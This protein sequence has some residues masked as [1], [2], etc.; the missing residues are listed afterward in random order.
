MDGYARSYDEV[1]LYMMLRPCDC[2]EIELDRE[3]RLSRQDGVW[4]HEYSGYCPRCGRERRFSFRMPDELPPMGGPRYGADGEPSQLLDPGEWLVVADGYEERAAETRDRAGARGLLA[5][6][7]A[8]TDEVLKFVPDGA[9]EVPMSAFWRDS[10]LELYLSARDR[11]RA[12]SLARDAADRRKAAADLD[13]G[14]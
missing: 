7:A 5:S 4:V 3:R 13:T 9:G 2:G 12:D 6:A 8:A 11:F 1:Y 14:R 10:S